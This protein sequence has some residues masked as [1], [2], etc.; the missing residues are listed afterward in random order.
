MTMRKRM[1]DFVVVYKWNLIGVA[2]LLVDVVFVFTV[3]HP[4]WSAVL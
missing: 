2:I 3:V 4:V 1:H